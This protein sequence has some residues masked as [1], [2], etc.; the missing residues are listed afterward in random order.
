MKIYILP[1][2][3]ELRPL[4]QPFLFPKHNLDYGIEQDFFNFLN[5]NPQYITSSP[6]EA[7]WHYLPVYWTRWH[8]NHNYGD[9]EGVIILSEHLEGV[10]LD[11]SKTFT[12][13]Q[14]G[15]GPKI[16]LGGALVY[17]G[18]RKIPAGSDAPL[19]CAAHQKPFFPVR[20]KFLA[21]FAG[22]LET[23]PIRGE[24]SE[25]LF[26]KKD[27]QVIS[28][29]IDTRDYINLILGSYSS[30]APR[31]YGGDSFRFYESMQLGVMPILI[32]DIDVRPF[33]EQL[34][35]EEMSIY[36]QNPR[37]LLQL[38]IPKNRKLFLSMGRRAHK[39]FYEK[40]NYQKWC[41]LLVN[42]LILKI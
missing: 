4:T 31:G 14:Y 33:K 15:D 9:E 28:K 7:S 13:C 20:K 21:S 40:L 27:I 36:V 30:L 1:V 41:S 10:I 29:E 16:S 23:H 24:M 19:L 37:D 11:D 12:V 34:N 2:S 39:A 32:G 22:R 26:E 17:L 35:W 6:S 5:E 42:D 25:I 18:S 3:D 38:L 8:L